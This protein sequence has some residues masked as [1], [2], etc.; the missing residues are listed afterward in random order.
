MKF[1][2]KITKSSIALSV[3]LLTPVYG[4]STY[5]DVCDIDAIYNE[6]YS[7]SMSKSMLESFLSGK[8]FDYSEYYSSNE[9]DSLKADIRDIFQDVV[10]SPVKDKIAVL[11]AGSPGVGK[12]TLMR[13][14]LKKQYT[15]YGRSFSYICPDDVC[16]KEQTRTYL[17]DISIDGSSFERRQ[18]AYT[19]WRPGSNAATHLI[20]ANLIKR[21]YG[22]FF[23]TTCSSPHTG[24]LLNFLKKQGYQ[25]KILHVSAPDD[26]RWKSI[27]ERNKTFVQTTEQDTREKGLLVPQ[28][29]QDTFLQYADIVEFYYRDG[30]FKNAILSAT[31][32]RKSEQNPIGELYIFDQTGY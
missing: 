2:S 27:Q 6:E 7:Y 26:I 1:L 3:M 20:L 22:F 31:W 24:K 16:L 8:A 4:Q 25:I 17:A 10:K 28:R 13:Q 11:S 18:K 21:E 9:L 19:K 30:V 14:H 23:G 12:T 29:I 32:N 5:P 15:Q